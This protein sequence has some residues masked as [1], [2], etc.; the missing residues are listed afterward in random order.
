MHAS[1]LAALG[2]GGDYTVREV[3]LDGLYAGI[4]ELRE[5]GL[6]G[7]N[8]TM[9]YKQVA[10]EMADELSDTAERVG[11]VNTLTAEAGSL[12]GANTDVDGVRAAFVAADLPRSDRVIVLEQ[13]AR[14]TARGHSVDIIGEKL[15]S[16]LIREVGASPIKLR[17]LPWSHS[18]GGRSTSWRVT[19]IGRIELSRGREPRRRWSHGMSRYRQELWSMRRHWVCAGSDYPSD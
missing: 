1:A 11:A 19:S 6:D 17:R 15:S 14:L 9:P 10:L 8:V 3:D 16:R 4:G 12:L 18:A 2:I 13:T 5:G 7:A